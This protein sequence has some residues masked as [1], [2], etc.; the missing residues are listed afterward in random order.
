MSERADIARERTPAAAVCLDSRAQGRSTR[1]RARLSYELMAHD[2]LACLD[3][4]GVRRAHLVG[5]SDGAIEALLVARDHPDRAL[6]LLAI[7]ANLTPEGV[8]EEDGWDLAG[9]ARAARSWAAWAQGLPADG[10]VDPTLLCP[11]AGEARDGADLLELM[12]EEPH[13]KASS[14][15]AVRC[16]ATIVAG[17]HDCVRPEETQ[18]IYEGI[19]SGG[20]ERVRLVVVSDCAHNVPKQAPQVAAALALE[21]IRTA[22]PTPRS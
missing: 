19:C 11:T 4:L 2:A 13:I 16:P 22:A 5:F 21:T 15:A 6:S 17:E 20:N 10:D 14:L 1:G 7:G 18:A 8:V 9:S 12:L 3:A